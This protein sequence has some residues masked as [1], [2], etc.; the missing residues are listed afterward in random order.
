MAAHVTYASLCVQ[1]RT[2]MHTME[3][4]RVNRPCATHALVIQNHTRMAVKHG[5]KARK[6]PPITS[7][8]NTHLKT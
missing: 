3:R 1:K 6:L 8:M 2:L 4:D 7:V 5:I